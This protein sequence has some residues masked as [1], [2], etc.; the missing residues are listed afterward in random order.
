[1][2]IMHEEKMTIKIDNKPT[3]DKIMH[4]GIFVVHQALLKMHSGGIWANMSLLF[5]LFTM[6]YAL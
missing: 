4:H 1:M 2:L 5:L 6:H 3:L